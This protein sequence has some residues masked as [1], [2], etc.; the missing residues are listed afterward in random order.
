MLVFTSL[1]HLF[2][3]SYQILTMDLLPAIPEAQ[4]TLPILL[5]WRPRFAG[6]AKSVYMFNSILG[7]CRHSKNCGAPANPGV[8][9]STFNDVLTSTPD[10]SQ[11]LT[12]LN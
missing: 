8:I 4:A 2:P 6:S 10:A 9:H 12:H 7:A 5:I 3:P 11:L 1:L